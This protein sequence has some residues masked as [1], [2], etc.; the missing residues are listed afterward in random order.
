MHF[1]AFLQNKLRKLN[2]ENL[3]SISSI[4]EEKQA[5]ITYYRYLGQ[6]ENIVNECFQV[7]D[8]T[9]DCKRLFAELEQ[10]L[11]C[12]WELMYAEAK[13]YYCEHGNLLVPARYISSNR[14]RLGSCNTSQR[15]IRNGK[16]SGKLTAEQIERLETIA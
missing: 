13:K 15:M 10:R 8:E 4:Q 12:S 6:Y 5:A 9:R 14:I 7:I 16:Q 3:H 11:N 2:I 1:S